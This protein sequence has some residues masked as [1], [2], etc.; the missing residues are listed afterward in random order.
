M[1]INQLFDGN[2]DDFNKVMDFLENCS[3]QSEAMDFINSNYL[4]KN[5]WKKDSHEV[6]EFIKVVALK[7]T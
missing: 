7:Y 6:K 3:T 2:S 1:F 4:K 5:N